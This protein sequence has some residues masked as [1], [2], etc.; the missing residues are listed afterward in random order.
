MAER[1][2]PGPWLASAAIAVAAGAIGLLAAS[3]PALSVGLMVGGAF[4]LI[5]FNNLTA[6]LSAMILLAYLQTLPAVA[7]SGLSASKVAS[8]VLI[9]AWFAL[10]T[11]RVRTRDWFWVSHPYLTALLAA[12]LVWTT[13]SAVWAESSGAALTSVGSYVLAAS[14]FPIAFSAVQSE[15]DVRRLLMVLAVAAFAAAVYGFALQPSADAAS[16][17]PD[18]AGQLDRLSG[19]IGD[20]NQF[21]ARALPGAVIAMALAF[22]VKSTAGRVFFAGAA[23]ACV[24]ATVLSL[25][26]GGL[27]ALFAIGLIAPLVIAPARGRI[28]LAS[29][30]GMAAAIAVFFVATPPEARERITRSDGG[31]GRTDIWNIGWRMV[32]AQPVHGVG[33]GNFE[34]SSIH[35]LVRPGAIRFD[36]YFV[37]DPKV[38]HNTYLHVLAENGI[39]GA[40]LF[41]AITG[42]ATACAMRAAQRFRRIGARELAIMSEG[43][44]IAVIGVLVANFFISEQLSKLVWLLLAIGPALL[45]LARERERAHA[46]A[47]GDAV[48]V[49]G[50]TSS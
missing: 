10:V 28:A 30:A 46:A 15:T 11:T 22:V 31:N 2:D 13:L 41:L 43:L 16:G 25:S 26:R 1:I 9:L 44:V 17:A 40:A 48:P 33:A 36:E 24:A 49:A 21:A 39:V 50:S 12:F 14:L 29:L 8:A 45:A 35:Y 3:D 5:A 6:G 20:P 19:S 23:I 32:E 37:D 18:A 38:A 42:A 34:I 7:G 27:I 4:L 47:A